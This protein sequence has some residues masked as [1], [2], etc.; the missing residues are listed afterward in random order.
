VTVE[1]GY[2][3]TRPHSDTPDLDV[4]H[5]EQWAVMVT[6]TRIVGETL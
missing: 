4:A 6:S 3:T 2:T 5:A 1:V